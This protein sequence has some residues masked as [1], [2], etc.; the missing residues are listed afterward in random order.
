[1]FGNEN[2]PQ[3]VRSTYDSNTGGY[4]DVRRKLPVNSTIGKII[5]RERISANQQHGTHELHPNP[6]IHQEEKYTPN[7]NY[8]SDKPRMLL[9]ERYSGTIEQCFSKFARRIGRVF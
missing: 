8:I 6:D 9:R 2:Q 1:M 3:M 7:S 4:G 5:S